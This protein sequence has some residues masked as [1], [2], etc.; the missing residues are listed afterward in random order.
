MDIKGRAS[1][2]ECLQGS[3]IRADV[4]PVPI[5]G[6]VPHFDVITSANVLSSD[7]RNA[8]D[9]DGYMHRDG[10]SVEVLR[11]KILSAKFLGAYSLEGNTVHCFEDVS[12]THPSL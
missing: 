10:T 6:N 5:R 11:N 1:V 7:V 3:D 9:D 8:L 12:V 4:M 2:M